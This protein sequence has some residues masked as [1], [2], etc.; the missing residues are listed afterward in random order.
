MRAHGFN[1]DLMVKLVRA[2]LAT[3]TSE[4]GRA[5]GLM[6]DVA[7]VRITEA[8]RRS[9]A[10][11]HFVMAVTDGIVK[12]GLVAPPNCRRRAARRAGS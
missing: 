1:I 9:P 12:C 7:R 8:G 6:L 4:R 2:G 10:K 11:H 3:A 5:G